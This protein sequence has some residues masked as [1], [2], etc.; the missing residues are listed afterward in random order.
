MLLPKPIKK[1]LAVFRG[2]VSPLF[3]FLSTALG[4]WFGLMPGFS[5]L[6]LVLLAAVFILN[7]HV[8]L[9]LLFA[10]L[11]KTVCFAAA[12]LLYYS[13]LALHN[14]VAPLLRL[15]A[16]LPIIGMTNFDRYAVA[17]A[18]L[19]GPAIG[20]ALGFV[21]V[22]LVVR[23]RTKMLAFE[24][25]S[26]KFKEWYS[27]SWVRI[28]DRILI[29]KRTA[30]MQSMFTAPKKNFRLP[31]VIAVVLLLVFFGAIIP[32]LSD[33]LIKT[34]TAAAMSW[35]NGAEVNIGRL[36]LAP[37]TG[38]ISLTGLQMTDPENLG[39]DRLYIDSMAAKAAVF[40]L[41]KGDFVLR[42][43]E[44][45]TVEFDRPRA[46][47][48]RPFVRQ[49]QPV[50]TPAKSDVELK[51]LDDYVADAEKI[52]EGFRKL[53]RWL[54]QRSPD[55]STTAS[56]PREVPS[57]YLAY[58]DAVAAVPASPRV[59]ARHIRLQGMA[60]PL[61]GF[62]D[63]LMTIANVSDA[64]AAARLPIKLDISSTQGD[65]ALNA[66]WDFSVRENVPAVSGA[67]TGVDIAAFTESF[68]SIGGLSFSNGRAAGLFAGHLSADAIDLTLDIT[69]TQLNAKGTGKGVLGL[70]AADTTEIFSAIDQITLSMHIAGETRRP[71]VS[72]DAEQFMAQ[73]QDALKKAGKQQLQRKL[74]E[75]L[76]DE[77]KG[78]EGIDTL[79]EPEKLIEGV[80]GLLKR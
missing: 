33:G 34:H 43:I 28:L 11:G 17:G 60:V 57:H 20:A 64:P 50:E 63:S 68:G 69:L 29:G 55:S 25:N 47:P 72:V 44:L 9:F 22:V 62:G 13:G 19:W 67:F 35:A 27:K 40:N 52:Y 14:N 73:I 6:H 51:P 45:E 49:N 54:P 23:F 38:N 46:A 18:V 15:L 37:L 74:Q 2:K 70:R 77:L 53:S 21:L 66:L 36:Q 24:Q 7:V 48:G 65:A 26:P 30:D 76:P 80:R 10:G 8:G 31:G 1:M 3:I 42:D 39:S 78:I 58:L 61:P 16:S 32:L 75:K 71:H 41:L 5:G 79:K 12:P 56:A 59:L 4:F